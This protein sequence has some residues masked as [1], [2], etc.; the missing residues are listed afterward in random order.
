MRT[1]HLL[2]GNIMRPLFKKRGSANH[3]LKRFMKSEVEREPSMTKLQITNAPPTQK[4]NRTSMI[5]FYS[6]LSKQEKKKKNIRQLGL[7]K[8]HHERVKSPHSIDPHCH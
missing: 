1:L 7:T 6:T 3:W 2:E 5:F 4:E 8:Y